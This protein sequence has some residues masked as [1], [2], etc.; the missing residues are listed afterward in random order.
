MEYSNT[1]INRFNVSN[2][3]LIKVKQSV[4]VVGTAMVENSLLTRNN[5]L[6]EDSNQ[7]AAISQHTN[8]ECDANVYNEKY[9]SSSQK[10]C[11]ECSSDKS[12]DE[13]CKFDFCVFMHC[14]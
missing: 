8:E 5:K 2:E 9:I 4:K 1:Y 14:L 13:V 6:F 11:R 10:T 12:E 3:E 7:A